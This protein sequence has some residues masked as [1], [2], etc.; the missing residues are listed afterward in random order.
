MASLTPMTELE[1]INDMLSLIAETPLASL[2]EVD[3]VADAQIA[4]QLLAR[5]SRTVQEEDWDWNT[6]KDY[7]L[8]PDVDGNIILPANTLSVNPTDPTLDYVY[9]SGKLWDRTNKSFNI[10]TDVTVTIKLLLDFSDLPSTA[11]RYIATKAGR[12]FESRMIGDGQS[13]QINQRDEDKALADLLLDEAET[14]ELNAIK[15]SGPSALRRRF[16]EGSI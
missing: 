6:E 15:D 10:G 1:A 7:V 2:L 13:Y 5:T 8:S 16:R 9:R 11:R 12:M 4:R 14:A 3:G